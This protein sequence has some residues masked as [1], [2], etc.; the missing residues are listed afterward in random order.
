MKQ[1]M[2]EMSGCGNLDQ[3]APC[4][5]NSRATVGQDHLIDVGKVAEILS[6]SER[7]VWRLRNKKRIPAGISL[8]RVVRWSYR[9]IM[10]WIAAGCPDAGEMERSV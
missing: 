7:T 9:A 8:G 4:L 3:E 5:D 10:D 6:C 1:R 2:T